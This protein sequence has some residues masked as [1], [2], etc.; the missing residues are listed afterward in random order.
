MMMMMTM[1]VMMV[2]GGGDHDNDDDDEDEDELVNFND[3]HITIHRTEKDGGCTFHHNTLQTQHSQYAHK[4]P[5]F[6]YKYVPVLA[7]FCLLSLKFLELFFAF[8]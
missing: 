5:Y 2:G 4:K 3:D 1:M 7:S 6:L 8:L